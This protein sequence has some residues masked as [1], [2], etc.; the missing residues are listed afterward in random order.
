MSFGHSYLINRSKGKKMSCKQLEK[1]GII[2]H[3]HSLNQNKVIISNDES[4]KW[5]VEVSASN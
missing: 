5:L 3:P 2:E 1:E 4:K